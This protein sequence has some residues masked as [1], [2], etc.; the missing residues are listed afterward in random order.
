MGQYLVHTSGEVIDRQSKAYVVKAESKEQAQELARENFKQDFYI[1]EEC[2]YTRPYKRSWKIVFAILFMLIPVG[3]S[4]VGWYKGH[5]VVR[6]GPSYVSCIYAITIYAAFVTRFKGLDRV[7]ETKLDIALCVILLL[8]ISSFVQTIL[9]EKEIGL[10]IFKGTVDAKY[11]LFGAAVLS[12]CGLKF[13][14]VL[15]MASVVFLALGNIAKLSDAM[16][17]IYGTMY[18]ICSFIGLLLYLSVEPAI[19]EGL[20][21]LKKSVMHGVDY[22]KRDFIAAGNTAHSIG[23]HAK[24]YGGKIVYNVKRGRNE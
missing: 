10:W 1:A 7:F 22:M 23:S 9:V 20:P 18:I 16:G 2:I 12:W 15:C 4:F 5:D 8:L 3:L 17:P 6:I 24:K 19:I 21:S 13:V 11:I 14:S